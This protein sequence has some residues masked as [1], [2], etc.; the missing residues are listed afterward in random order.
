MNTASGNENIDAM[1][2]RLMQEKTRNEMRRAY[3]VVPP[4]F[5][6]SIP[7]VT[8]PFESEPMTFRMF[9]DYNVKMFRIPIITSRYMDSGPSPAP[10]VKPVVWKDTL[11]P[12]IVPA[13]QWCVVVA[14]LVALI[15]ATGNV[16]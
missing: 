5:L 14:C 10:C 7:M 13:W 4:D 2:K 11:K 12:A 8:E 1:I 6:S 16:F 3:L 15:V 9:Q